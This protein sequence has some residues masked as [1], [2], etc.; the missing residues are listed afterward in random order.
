VNAT[1][2]ISESRFETIFAQSPIS[3]QIFTPQGDMIAANAAWRRLWG[4]GDDAQRELNLLHDPQLVEQG[5]VPTIARAFAGESLKVEKVK[6]TSPNPPDDP[7]ELPYRWVRGHLYPV[8]DEGGVV[9]EVVLMTEDITERILAEE[10]AREEEERYLRIFESTIDGLIINDP[11]SGRV[12]NANPA[13]C[14]MHGY[15]VDEFIGLHAT[16][17]IHPDFHATFAEFRTTIAAGGDY[18]TQAID[19]RKDG[20]P[21]Y[22]EVHGSPLTY[23]G[24]PH[25]LAV[26]RDVTERVEARHVLEQAVAERTHELSTLLTVSHDVASTLQ[27]DPLIGLILNQLKVLIDYA[28]AGVLEVQGEFLQAIGYRGPVPT[29][30]ALQARF[31]ILPGMGTWPAVRE[32]RPVIIHDVHADTP[33][34]VTYRRE[35]GDA[36]ETV[37]S[38]VSS[39]LAVPM[40]VGNR[41]IGV[42]SMSH[43]DRN[44]F[45]PERVALVQAVASQAAVAIENARLYERAQEVAV[46]EERHRLSR[47]LH[48]SVSQALYSIALGARTAAAMADQAPERVMEPIEFVLAQAERGLAEMRALIFELRPDV[49]EDEGLTAALRRQAEAIRVRYGLTVRSQLVDEPAIATEAKEALFRIAQEALH[50]IVKHAGAQSVEVRLDAAP[51]SLILQVRDDG[52]GFDTSQSFPGHL[53]LRSM[54]ERMVRLG[55][56]LQLTSEADG[57]SIVRAVLPLPRPPAT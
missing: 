14:R 54:R 9:R 42:L 8:L 34:A 46:L 25:I 4:W 26:V 15:T 37:F 21:F 27:L 35:S 44:Y 48:D 41:T 16:E 17:F 6:Y 55:G 20:S 45:T 29:Q 2:S 7:N 40:V 19:V 22:V 12:V 10:Q 57:G 56:H 1:G 53:G 51:E 11:I 36:F 32:Q 23:R 3:I 50:N 31:P 39:F 52:R 47:E 13:V 18:E 28:D 43:G 38:F 33:E 5:L 24:R 49:I 30:F